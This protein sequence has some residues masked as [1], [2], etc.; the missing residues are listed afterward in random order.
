MSKGARRHRKGFAVVLTTLSDCA[1]ANLPVRALF[2]FPS[3]SEAGYQSGNAH[4][5]ACRARLQLN[6]NLPAAVRPAIVTCCRSSWATH[7]LSLLTRVYRVVQ[8]RW[9]KNWRGCGSGKSHAV[10]RLCRG[11]RSGKLHTLVIRN[12]TL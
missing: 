12:L 8:V 9:C 11:N 1:S 6:R 5:A 7:R 3:R 2:F 10:I 4:I